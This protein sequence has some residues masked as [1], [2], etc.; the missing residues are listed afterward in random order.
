[1]KSL[2]HFVLMIVLLIFALPS[3]AVPR[4]ELLAELEQ[5]VAQKKDGIQVWINN[6]EALPL[7][8]GS[9]LEF[10]F[11]SSSDVYLTAVYL[12]A[13][14]NVVLLLPAPSPGGTLFPRRSFCRR[15]GCPRATMRPT[16]RSWRK[17]CRGRRDSS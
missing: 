3:S 17:Y 16:T 2:R 13:A 12:D 8:D 4:D 6:G 9:P 5:I 10:H 14:G 15:T 7:E 1:M 11:D